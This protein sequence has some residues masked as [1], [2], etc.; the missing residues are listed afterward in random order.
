MREQITLTAKEA[1]GLAQ[2]LNGWAECLESDPGG[3]DHPWIEEMQAH[4][5]LLRDKLMGRSE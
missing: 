1:D 5:R 4:A 2:D 3:G